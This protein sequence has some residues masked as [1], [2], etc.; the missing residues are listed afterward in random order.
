[1]MSC[2]RAALLASE[3]RQSS[4]RN[5]QPRFLTIRTLYTLNLQTHTRVPHSSHFAPHTLYSSH[6]APHTLYPTP[7]PHPH[8]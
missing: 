6:P 8:P 2:F 3:H 4:A 7:H 5:L 1:M